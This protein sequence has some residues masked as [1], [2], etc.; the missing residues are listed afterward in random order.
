[1]NLN[2]QLEIA[3]ILRTGILFDI[4]KDDIILNQLK[5]YAHKYQIK[6]TDNTI[7]KIFKSFVIHGNNHELIKKYN[8]NNNYISDVLFFRQVKD[9]NL[10]LLAKSVY[11]VSG[12]PYKDFLIWQIK[13]ILDIGEINIKNEYIK[14]LK[15]IGRDEATITDFV[16]RNTFDF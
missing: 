16:T 1:M 13:V 5:E 7:E 10:T 15:S 12:S 9:I 14:W 8:Y 3:K 4:Q 2:K 11:A 6:E